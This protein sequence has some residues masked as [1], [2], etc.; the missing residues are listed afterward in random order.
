MEVKLF[1][2]AKYPMVRIPAGTFTMGASERTPNRFDNERPAHSI[3]LLGFWMGVAP[4][5][6]AQYQAFLTAESQTPLTCSLHAEMSSHFT[7]PDRPAVC[8]TWEQ[9]S[10]FCRWAGLVLPTEAQWEYACRGATNTLYW[11]GDTEEDLAR[12]GWYGSNSLSGAQPVGRKPANPYGLCDMHGNVWE[13]CQD[14][15]DE[16]AYDKPLRP[17]DGLREVP[18][19]SSHVIRGGAWCYSARVAAASTRTYNGL[20]EAPF[21]GFRCVTPA[22]VL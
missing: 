9:A 4:V 13:W 22:G 11:S 7:G 2:P 16:R 12:V 1:G 20:P 10:G 15:Y 17:G 19:G 14:W 5:T 8:V 21:I 18:P 6:Q 3:T